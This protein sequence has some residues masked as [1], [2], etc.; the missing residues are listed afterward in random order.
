EPVRRDL[1]SRL[2][3]GEKLE[4]DFAGVEVLTPSFADECLGR[5]V[6]DVGVEVFRERVRLRTTD[7][8]I[9]RLVNHVLSHRSAQVERARAKR[10]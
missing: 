4:I 9:K 5:L 8:T 1:R 6:L 10:G 2:G 3:R 7:E